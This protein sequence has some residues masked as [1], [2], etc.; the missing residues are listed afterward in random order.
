ML[1]CTHL[2]PRV[3]RVV[4]GLCGG[5]GCPLLL[6]GLSVIGMKRTEAEAGEWSSLWVTSGDL[7]HPV[8]AHETPAAG[9]LVREAADVGNGRG[10]RLMLMHGMVHRMTSMAS[11]AVF[12]MVG[13]A[14]AA[15]ADYEKTNQDPRHPQISLENLETVG[16]FLSSLNHAYRCCL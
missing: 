15:E 14:E 4:H 3:K 9:Q 12:G 16:L 13:L 7:E 11:V 6:L 8:H 1:K 2:E 10:E 5:G